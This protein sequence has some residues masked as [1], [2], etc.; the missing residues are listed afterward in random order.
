MPINQYR[1]TRK[2]SRRLRPV[3]IPPKK[4]ALEISEPDTNGTFKQDWKAIL[5]AIG[6]ITTQPSTPPPSAIPATQPQ[7]TTT[8][9][10]KAKATVPLSYSL[11]V[12]LRFLLLF[13]LETKPNSLPSREKR[14][15]NCNYRSGRGGNGR[16]ANHATKCRFTYQNKFP[17]F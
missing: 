2:S 4:L 3:T 6:L 16:T 12:F 10:A 14:F 11:F 15:D 1:A 8:A 5:V 17:W 7:I 13:K 9:K